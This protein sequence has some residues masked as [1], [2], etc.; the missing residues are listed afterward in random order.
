MNTLSIVGLF[1]V[2]FLFAGCDIWNPNPANMK[3]KI[4]EIQNGDKKTIGKYTYNAS[5][6]MKESWF[7]EDSYSENEKQEY[8]YTFNSEGQLQRKKGYEPGIIYMS[9]ITGAMGK[10]V[11]YS[12]EYDSEGR[13][14]KIRVDLDYDDKYN[15]DYSRLT[16][17]QYPEK[18][19]VISSTSI[20]DPLGNSLA[21]SLEYHFDPKGNIE[22]TVGYYMVSATEKR[23][24][25]ESVF[26]YDTKKSPYCVDPGPIS[27]N[28]VLTEVNTVFNYDDFGNRTI[29]YTSEFSFDYEYNAEGYPTSKTET[30]TNGTKITN[31]YKYE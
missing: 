8:I 16:T 2:A 17:F 14:I 18:T 26:T 23:I 27:E 1:I 6:Q 10:D 31:Y 24:F 11:D 22:K 20:I 21:S 3:G 15:A 25:Q 4:T 19:I 12:Y 29:A 30:Y 28:N 5:G 13:I 9:S 7:T